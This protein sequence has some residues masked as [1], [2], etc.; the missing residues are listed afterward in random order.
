MH[1]SLRHPHVNLT[2]S[3][4]NAPRF[5]ADF[6][7]DYPVQGDVAPATDASPSDASAAGFVLGDASANGHADAGADDDDD[8]LIAM[9][10]GGV[11]APPPDDA[12]P[13]CPAVTEWRAAFAKGLEDKV[14]AERA[15]KAERAQRARQTL[16]SMH[17]RWES[18]AKDA[19]ERNQKQ[20]KEFVMQRDG[21]ISRM[22]KPGE[23]PSWD[24]VPELVDMSGKFKEGARDTSR[25]RQV[26]MR[27]K[28]N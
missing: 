3:I 16:T 4:R 25:M 27:M 14:A 13:E 15:T 8:P 26:L 9:P 21:V 28:T 10:M 18:A 5:L 6:F 19:G 24:I 22:S 11:A 1:A 12:E 23:K 17:A 20:E 7:K 2:S